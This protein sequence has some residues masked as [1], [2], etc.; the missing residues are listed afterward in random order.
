MSSGPG[1]LPF[2]RPEMTVSNSSIVKGEG[3]S[4]EAERVV[5]KLITIVVPRP[6]P[7]RGPIVFGRGILRT[8]DGFETL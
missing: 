5:R 7:V 3:S 8:H 4:G 1:A 6:R 2:L